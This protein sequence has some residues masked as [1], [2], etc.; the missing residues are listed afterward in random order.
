MEWIDGLQ[1]ELVG[2]DTAPLIY[3]IEEHPTY[4]ESMR[5]FLK[6]YNDHLTNKRFNRLTRSGIKW[7]VRKLKTE[8]ILLQ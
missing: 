8:N 4:L 6:L 3:F 2:L 7:N 5:Y 1:G